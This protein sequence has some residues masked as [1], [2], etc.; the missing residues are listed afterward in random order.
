[1]REQA[2]E[3]WAVVRESYQSFFRHLGP[4]KAGSIA[5]FATLSLF[6]LALL[7][8]SVAA[9]AV[10]SAQAVREIASLI[11]QY[12]P[13]AGGPVLDVLEKTRV[14]GQHVL[15]DVVG[16]FGLLWSATNL[17]TT[18]SQVLTVVWWSEPKRGF[19]HRR[20]VSLLA[21][22]AAGLLFLASVVL[23]GFL[24]A[25]KSY[26][27]AIEPLAALH[28]RLHFLDSPAA[29]VLHAT[30]VA[31]ML[32]LLYWTMPSGR[33]AVKA[34]V[35]AAVSA[36]LLWMASRTV[37]AVLVAGSSRYGQGIYGPLAGAVIL[38]LW[39]YYSA[40]IMIFCGEIGR[41][42]QARYWPVAEVE[43]HPLAPSP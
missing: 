43:P 5:F 13:R 39:I 38:L 29:W 16:A 20:V 35:A 27:A 28:Q 4:L 3:L 21:V 15:V 8:V 42:L 24:A 18:L 17:F 22:I 37:F 7:L 10:G 2:S 36:A 9:R 41:T 33:V 26:A 11:E 30:V 1:M 23:T 6:P 31:I 34:A 40:Y 19:L 12:M 32:F 25:I 14:S